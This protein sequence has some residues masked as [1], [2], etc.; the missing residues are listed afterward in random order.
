MEFL[1]ASAGEDL[2]EAKEMLRRDVGKEITDTTN[3]DVICALRLT[4]PDPR[5]DRQ[6]QCPGQP[7]L[8]SVTCRLPLLS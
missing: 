6:G 8:Y 1:A 3:R 5:G 4:R 7:A 2:L